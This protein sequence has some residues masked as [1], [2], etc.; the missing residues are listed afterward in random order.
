MTEYPSSSDIDYLL[1]L[2]FQAERL[3]HDRIYYFLVSE[4]IFFL[5]ASAVAK[6]AVVVFT[7]AGILIAI[8]FTFVNMRTYFRILWLIR[9]IEKD[10]LLY[11]EYLQFHKLSDLV[12]FG[13]FSHLAACLC[14]VPLSKSQNSHQDSPE[15]PAP[16]KWRDTGI[17]LTWWLFL[18]I[19][20]AWVLFF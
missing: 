15:S 18:I 5:A 19:L 20:A 12:E 17:L 8:L 11:R 10:D 16:I 1:K 13:C 3:Q 2:L 6:E 7:I 14:R 4:T 9:R